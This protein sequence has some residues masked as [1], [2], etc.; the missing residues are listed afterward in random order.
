MES[1]MPL[2]AEPLFMG[3]L[4]MGQLMMECHASFA[5]SAA[6]ADC[7]RLR[8][9]KGRRRPGKEPDLDWMDTTDGFQGFRKLDHFPN[10]ALAVSK[11][12]KL[13]AGKV[14]EAP[15]GFHWGSRAEAA[16]IMGGGK[17]PRQPMKTHCRG[18]GGW[19]GYTWGGVA[20]DF[21]VFSDSLQVG[22]YL[23]AGNGE[24]Y[25]QESGAASLARIL[26]TKLFA[27]I[28]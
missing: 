22:G 24:G 2:M 19:G 20:R 26:P 6:A 18:Q 8:P 4:L 17:E 3:H 14:Y 1:I 12:G 27:G 5:T 11:A 10:V 7:R 25:I 16:A 15:A 13:E 21:F 28:V 9:R 23:H